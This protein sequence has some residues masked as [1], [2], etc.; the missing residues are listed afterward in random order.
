MRLSPGVD[1]VD[2]RDLLEHGGAE[3]GEHFWSRE[4]ISKGNQQGHTVYE[5]N[6]TLEP[7]YDM[8]CMQNI[9]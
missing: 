9:A 3:N 6:Q 4:T 7:Q 5:H 8:T 1:G 2:V